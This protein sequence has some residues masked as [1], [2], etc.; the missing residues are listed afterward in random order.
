MPPAP[1]TSP[2]TARPLPRDESRGAASVARTSADRSRPILILDGQTTQALACVRSLGR[3]GHLPLVASDRAW[4]LAAWSRHCHDRI[5][6]AA[7]TRAGYASLRGWARERGVAAVLPLTERSCVLCNLDRDR[8]EDA[9][10]VVGCGPAEMLRE[11]F[12]K[13]RTV[14][15]AAAN[16][17]RTPRTFVPGSLEDCRAGAEAVGWPCVVKPRF[18]NAWDGAA[19]L[20]DIPPAYVRDPR[21][22]AEAVERRRQGDCWPIIQ[23]W[24]PGT[25]KGAFALFD[26]GRPVAWFA[27]RRLRDVRPSGSGSS[28]RESIALDARLRDP[29]ERLL[30]ALRWHGP[31]MVE[32][33]DDGSSAPWLIEINGRFWGSLQL[34]VAAGVD[35]PRLWAAVLGGV[36]VPPAE[37][38]REGVVS[39]WVW[40]DVKRLLHVAAGPPAGFPGAWPSLGA[41]LR[42][43]LGAQPR[44]T[45]S[46]TWEPSDPWPAVG[47]WV[48]GV[49][50]LVGR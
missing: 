47:E 50:E 31:A 26:D 45:R 48:Q 37:P 40:G 49:R 38:Y 20:A 11:A 42:E 21:Q 25:G 19:F 29:A 43:V 36:S 22:L 4:P 30:T 14:A 6:I 5:R 3:A 16:G 7:P 46:E 12:D 1:S 27:H 24:V 34:A 17:V 18:S 28:L 8:W 41:A 10:I 35:F 2:P 39:R 9:G 15:A 23:E 33:R 44:G 13:A 32:F